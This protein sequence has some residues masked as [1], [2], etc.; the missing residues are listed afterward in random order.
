MA[1][2]LITCPINVLLLFRCKGIG[3]AA[4]KF[5]LSVANPS[6]VALMVHTGNEDAKNFYEKMGCRVTRVE[7]GHYKRSEQPDAFCMEYIV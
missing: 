4:W 5:F 1:C 7:K 3:T 2:K 6:K